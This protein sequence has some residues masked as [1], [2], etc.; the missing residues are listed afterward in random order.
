MGGWLQFITGPLPGRE[1]AATYDPTLVAL[2]YLVAS[3]AAYC[4]VD[5]AGQVRE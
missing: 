2:S 1:L 4:A 5:L 3:F